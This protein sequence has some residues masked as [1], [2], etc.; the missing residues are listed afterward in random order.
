MQCSGE[1]NCRLLDLKERVVVCVSLCCDEP[2]WKVPGGEVF[3]FRLIVLV[4]GNAW[5]L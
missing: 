2:R 5:R 3:V 4:G 1:E